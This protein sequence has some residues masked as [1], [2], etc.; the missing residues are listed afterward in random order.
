MALYLYESGCTKA[1]TARLR[2]AYKCLVEEEKMK[3]EV[4]LVY[5]HDS[6]N[7]LGSTNAESF[8]KDFGTMPWLSLPFKD[9][10]C[11]KVQRVV[12]YPFE[13]GGPQPDPSLVIVGPF[14]KFFEP[15]GASDVL[16][17]FG[18][19]AYPFTRET[20]FY[21]QVRNIKKLKLGMLWD[22][23]DVFIRGCMNQVIFLFSML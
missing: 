7:T 17:T 10:N 1:L 6:W 12:R 8:M 11:K 21:L 19:P 3:F 22:P 5:I 15:F 9:P 13:L 20:A 14:G 4:V 16:M 23:K 18:S 2:D